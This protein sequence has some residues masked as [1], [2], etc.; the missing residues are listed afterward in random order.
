MANTNIKVVAILSILVFLQAS[1]TAGRHLGGTPAVMS[2]NSFGWPASCDG[3]YHSDSLFLVSLNSGW[4]G[5]GIRCGKMIRIR[6]PGGPTV[7]AMVL[8]ECE[9][10]GG[11]GH[12]EMGTSVAV[13]NALGIDPTAG[14]VSVTWSYLN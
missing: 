4:Y 11:C 5:G 12:H 13:W 6:S 9:I 2:L 8:D 3:K 10:R 14:P 7:E 1:C